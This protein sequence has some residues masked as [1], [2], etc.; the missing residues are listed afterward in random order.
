MIDIIHADI[1]SRNRLKCKKAAGKEVIL[2]AGTC[3]LEY[4]LDLNLQSFLGAN[5]VLQ[6]GN[7]E[8]FTYLEKILGDTH[9]ELCRAIA[10]KDYT[11]NTANVPNLK[12]VFFKRPSRNT[13]TQL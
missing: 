4:A 6:Y 9:K 3:N 13:K 11:C 2:D 12:K 8:F 5:K 7:G 10:K 1:V